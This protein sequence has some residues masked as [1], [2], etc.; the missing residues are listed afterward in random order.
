MQTGLLPG[1]MSSIYK[2]ASRWM[3]LYGKP[4]IGINS[5][6][7]RW[8]VIIINLHAA[9]KKIGRKKSEKI[10]A[11]NCTNLIAI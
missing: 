2:I 5:S 1:V 6:L 3:E 7:V 4:I 10:G 8:T 9:P 11:D